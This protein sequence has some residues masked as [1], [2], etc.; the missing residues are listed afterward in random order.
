LGVAIDNVLEF[1]HVSMNRL[2]IQLIKKKYYVMTRIGLGFTKV[3]FDHIWP[4]QMGFKLLLTKASLRA[5]AARNTRR[6]TTGSRRHTARNK[7]A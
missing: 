1:K 3:H 7:W 5:L 6:S 2:K 4:E